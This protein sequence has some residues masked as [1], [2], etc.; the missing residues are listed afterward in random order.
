MPLDP[1]VVGLL[2]K[3]RLIVIWTSSLWKD[4]KDASSAL[5]VTSEAEASF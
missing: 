5:G 2:R 3:I 1:T 4:L